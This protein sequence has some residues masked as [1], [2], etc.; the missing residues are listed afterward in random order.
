MNDFLKQAGTDALRTLRNTQ[1]TMIGVI[2]KNN[3]DGSFDLS[4]KGNSGL[5]KSVAYMGNQNLQ[6]GDTVL[7]WFMDGDRQRPLITF[8]GASLVSPSALTFDVAH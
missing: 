2:Q 3:G 5:M 6:V 8:C 7:V 1:E 4:V